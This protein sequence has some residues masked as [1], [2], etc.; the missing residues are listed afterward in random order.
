MTVLSRVIRHEIDV[1]N[2]KIAKTLPFNGKS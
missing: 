2:R 1:A